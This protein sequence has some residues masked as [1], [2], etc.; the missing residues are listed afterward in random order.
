M[1]ECTGSP[2]ELYSLPYV[3]GELP[4]V[5]VERFEQHYFECPA[6]LAYLQGLQSAGAELEKLPRAEAEQPRKVLLRWPAAVW[7]APIWG[8]AVAAAA[9]LI[10]A[11]FAYRGSISAPR[12]PAIA[13]SQPAGNP[14]SG[15]VPSPVPTQPAATSALGVKASQLADLALPAFIAPNLREA[16]EEIHFEAGMKAY[17]RGDCAAAA[18]TLAQ[19]PAESPAQSAAQSNE[20]R[21]AAFYRAACQIRLGDYAA[22]SKGMRSVADAGD[23]PQQESAI[24]YQAQLALASGN[25]AA[26]HRFLVRVIGL[27]GDLETKARAE[28][29]R[30]RD[31]IDARSQAAG[32]NPQS[33]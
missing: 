10:V 24:Y 6:C 7:P 25:P 22:A 19:V 5:E 31:L 27:R 26:A 16:T 30:V 29:A 28:D 3:E 15:P 33:R 14:V 32:A 9:V 18:A 20:S 1:N 4:E 21:A 23:S 13:Q 17:S 11:V 12:Q 2:A 8:V